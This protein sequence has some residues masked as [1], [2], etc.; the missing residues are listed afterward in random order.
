[1]NYQITLTEE[2]MELVQIG[3][4]LV[5]SDL[6]HTYGAQANTLRDKLAEEGAAQRWKAREE[7]LK[8]T[9]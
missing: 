7:A 2:E 6:P 1:M 8:I 4:Q 9:G 5:G 3:L